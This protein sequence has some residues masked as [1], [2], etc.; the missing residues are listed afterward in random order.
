M[1]LLRRVPPPAT[2]QGQGWRAH[3]D[4][5]GC[6]RGAAGRR[7]VGCLLSQ[8]LSEDEVAVLLGLALRGPPYRLH[9]ADNLPTHVRASCAVGKWLGNCVAVFRAISPTE[10]APSI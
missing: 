1:I 3:P 10:V 4:R 2:G 7:L 5:A 9:P 8:L 6:S